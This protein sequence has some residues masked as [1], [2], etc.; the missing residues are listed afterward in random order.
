MDVADLVSFTAL[1]LTLVLP[2]VIAG[3]AVGLAVASRRKLGYRVRYVAP[4]TKT[5]GVVIGSTLTTV[6]MIP[7]S[8]AVDTM[9]DTAVA[10]GSPEKAEMYRNVH[11]ALLIGTL[12]TY[13]LG[14]SALGYGFAWRTAQRMKWT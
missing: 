11:R 5:K 3:T 9:V 10:A 12:L 7:A 8:F 14:G 2:G 6:A 1:G 13:N 4:P